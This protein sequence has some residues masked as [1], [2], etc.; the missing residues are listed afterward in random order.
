MN[1]TGVL[2]ISPTRELAM[3][4]F[5]V[6]KVLIKETLQTTGIVMGGTRI[7]REK[8]CLSKGINLLIGTP[9]RLY[10]HMTNSKVIYTV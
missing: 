5:E 2:V 7:Q 10:D 9:G 3:Q 8:H 6:A 1:G 4:I